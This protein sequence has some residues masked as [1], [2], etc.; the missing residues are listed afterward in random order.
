[1]AKSGTVGESKKNKYVR[2]FLKLS[3]VSSTFNNYKEKCRASEKSDGIA[4]ILPAASGQFCLVSYWLTAS[5]PGFFIIPSKQ[6]HLHSR[7]VFFGH[8]PAALQYPSKSGQ[9]LYNHYWAFPVGFP[10]YFYTFRNG[11]SLKEHLPEAIG[12]NCAI[13]FPFP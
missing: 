11:H 5:F 13:Y 9:G 1:L 4:T 7:S 8:F 3:T 10:V 2:F 12:K 6:E